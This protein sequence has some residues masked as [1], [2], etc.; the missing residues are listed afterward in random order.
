MDTWIV[1]RDM[2]SGGERNRVIHIIK[3][4][5]M[6]HSNQLR[7]FLITPQGLELREAYVGRGQV[8]TGSARLIQE[9]ADLA[10]T[11]RQ[12]LE[13]ERRQRDGARQRRVIEA[14]IA[15][16]QTQLEAADD[17]SR[18][19][20]DEEQQSE[21]EQNRYQDQLAALR[22]VNGTRPTG[23]VKKPARRR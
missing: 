13:Q 23:Q 19:R 21:Q 3:S 9:A 2:E 22:R 12:R 8:Y 10:E 15:V 18:Q 16:L 6:A 1:F 11:T 17:D 7:E 14:Q 4:R 5:G 20:V